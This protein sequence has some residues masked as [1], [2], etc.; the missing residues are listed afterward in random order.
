[1]LFNVHKLLPCRVNGE[2][3][4]SKVSTDKI[5]ESCECIVGGLG[6]VTFMV[7]LKDFYQP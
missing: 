5:W 3:D 4:S 1:M 2:Q 7:G 6:S